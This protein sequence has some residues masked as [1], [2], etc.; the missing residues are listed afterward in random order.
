MEIGNEFGTQEAQHLKITSKGGDYWDKFYIFIVSNLV[1]GDGPSFLF[2]KYFSF[3]LVMST[4]N[5]F[6]YLAF[7]PSLVATIVLNTTD[8]L[9]CLLNT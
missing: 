9:T 6:C 2:V 3:P 8:N 4:I 7:L 5:I 1:L